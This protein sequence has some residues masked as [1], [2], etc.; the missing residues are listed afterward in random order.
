MACVI[1]S[2]TASAQPQP[3]AS[4]LAIAEA[5]F[6]E[7]KR[8]MN[9]ERHAE[10]C[11]KLAD[12]LRIAPGGG[13]ELALAQCYEAAGKLASAWTMYN[14]S[15]TTSRRNGR[16]D[17][18]KMAR[19]RVEAIEPRLSRLIL[20]LAPGNE[21]LAG[22]EI[23]TNGSVIPLSALGVPLPVDPGAQQVVVSAS[24]RKPWS[25]TV[26]VRPDADRHSLEIPLLEPLVPLAPA[27]AASATPSS[28]PSVSAAPAASSPPA[29]VSAAPVRAAPPS[30]LPA[31]GALGL[32]AVGLT[33]GTVVLLRARSLHE[34]SR[35]VCS[36]SPCSNRQAVTDSKDARSLANWSTVGFGVGLLGLAAGSYLLLSEPSREAAAAGRVAPW[37][38]VGAAGLDVRGAW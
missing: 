17:R 23:R 28:A 35:A 12:S 26:Q 37:V 11:P 15:I 25:I 20:R 1:A 36:S 22:L 3:S 24:G 2:S 13:A 16:A 10:A 14:Q 33:I 38:G 8:L 9:E 21:S 31:Y 30:R 18:E 27:S 6:Q 29:P 5:L 7:G 4:D 19:E 32:G 34:D